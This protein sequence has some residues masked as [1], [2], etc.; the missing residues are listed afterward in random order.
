M[1]GANSGSVMPGKYSPDKLKSRRQRA[2]DRGYLRRRDPDIS[3][4]AAP[5]AIAPRVKAVSAAL[6]F[7]S[8]HIALSGTAHALARQATKAVKDLIP[9]D[10]FKKAMRSHDVA[11]LAK[12]SWSD[13]QDL[14]DIDAL[15]FPVPTSKVRSMSIGIQT[16]LTMHGACSSFSPPL[17]PSCAPS[18][19][20]SASAVEFFPT[21]QVSVPLIEAQNNTTDEM[22]IDDGDPFSPP[23][24][25]SSANTQLIP[26]SAGYPGYLSLLEAQNQTIAVLT[27][28]LDA[29]AQASPPHRRLR[30]LEKKVEALRT[31]LSAS[32]STKTLQQFHELRSEVDM[33]FSE[34]LS[35]YVSLPS[36]NSMLMDLDE[37]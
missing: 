36:L 25:T 31:S 19:P 1:R 5:A 10:N 32:V 12:H 20:L 18:R 16:D 28:R 15:P 27:G 8:A 34:S 4:V 37:K 7:Q 21:S 33:K 24:P 35:N 22:V 9:T 26:S 14:D 29:L 6:A 2:A 13:M 3:F 23:R 17:P 11:N 30:E